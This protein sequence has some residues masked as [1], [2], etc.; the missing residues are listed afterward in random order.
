MEKVRGG[1]AIEWLIACCVASQTAVYGRCTPVWN[2]TVGKN[3]E[4]AFGTGFTVGAGLHSR[5]SKLSRPGSTTCRI[6]ATAADYNR[7]T[8]SSEYPRTTGHNDTSTRDDKRT[9]QCQTRDEIPA[10][11]Q[12]KM[13]DD[14]SQ[15]YV[16]RN[17]T[18]AIEWSQVFLL[19]VRNKVKCEIVVEVK[20]GLNR[21]GNSFKFLCVGFE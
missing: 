7:K 10:T 8:P 2:G 12:P 21:C 17:G 6:L 15:G 1:T 4:E 14:R 5:A 9:R 13:S 19:W 16:L 20:Q 3:L 11:L 18:D